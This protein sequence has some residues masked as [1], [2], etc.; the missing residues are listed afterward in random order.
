MLTTVFPCLPIASAS[1]YSSSPANPDYILP[2]STAPCEA[3]QTQRQQPAFIVLRPNKRKQPHQSRR[4]VYHLTRHYDNTITYRWSVT[5]TNAPAQGNKSECPCGASVDDFIVTPRRTKQR[6]QNLHLDVTYPDRPTHNYLCEYCR[7]AKNEHTAQLNKLRKKVSDN[8]KR[9]RQHPSLMNVP[10]GDTSTL[11]LPILRMGVNNQ[12][13]NGQGNGNMKDS[14]LFTYQP[15][16]LSLLEMNAIQ[17]AP[18]RKLKQEG[19]SSTSTNTGKLKQK[20]KQRHDIYD[21]DD[22]QVYRIEQQQGKVNLKR[23]SVHDDEL[24]ETR[25]ILSS[26]SSSSLSLSDMV[27]Y[28]ASEITTLDPKTIE[29]VLLQTSSYEFQ[30]V[31]SQHQ[32]HRKSNHRSIR[33]PDTNTSTV[34]SSPAPPPQS[35]LRMVKNISDSQSV[36]EEGFVSSESADKL[37]MVEERDFENSFESRKELFFPS[38]HGSRDELMNETEAALDEGDEYSINEEEQEEEKE[39][40]SS[41]SGSGSGNRNDSNGGEGVVEKPTQV[42]EFQQGQRHNS[43][44]SAVSSLNSNTGTVSH[45]SHPDDQKS[46]SS[47]NEMKQ[48]E[49]QVKN[50]TKSSCN[51][52][53]E[54]NNVAQSSSKETKST[55]TSNVSHVIPSSLSK[56][57]KTAGEKDK[58]E[59]KVETKKKNERQ[60]QV[61]RQHSSRNSTIDVS[62]IVYKSNEPSGGYRR[63]GIVNMDTIIDPGYSVP[64]NFLVEEGGGF[65]M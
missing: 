5:T 12:H 62:K 24:S 57:A 34:S 54:E 39:D 27:E 59:E 15:V 46:S 55:Q 29:R 65:M 28:E 40:G 56:T 8:T 35:R 11:V 33:R 37:Q 49:D 19:M 14:I 4:K 60:A 42:G 48:E 3:S 41:G 51:Q 36:N 1:P 23:Y 13:H 18:P 20:R 21:H 43:N 32:L 44:N 50:K 7:C 9:Q 47:D 25:S 30:R 10:H 53:S 17:F 2:R 45:H 63:T 6:K 26:S 38:F 64:L 61:Q 31:H 16:Y 52:L 22:D 58:K